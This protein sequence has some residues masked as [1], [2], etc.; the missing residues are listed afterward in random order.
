MLELA[1]SLLAVFLVGYFIG[2]Q[3]GYYNGLIEG[4]NLTPL[5][6]RSQSYEQGYCVLCH[7]GLDHCT[8]PENEVSVEIESE[9]TAYPAS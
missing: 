8:N 7:E 3:R 6:L 4:Q 2:R 5:L 1:I 9:K